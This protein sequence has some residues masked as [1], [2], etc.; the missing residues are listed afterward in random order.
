VPDPYAR[1]CSWYATTSALRVDEARRLGPGAWA[2]RTPAWSRSFVHNALLLTGDPGPE[3]VLAWSEQA[4]A[5][6]SHRHVSAYCQLSMA[7]LESL[8]A[9]CYQVQPEIVMGRTVAAGPIRAPHEVQVLAVPADDP[10]L[11]LLQARFWHEDWLPEAD[12]ATVGELV[13][14]RSEMGRAGTVTSVIVLDGG[15][16]VASLDVCVRGDIAEL[17][18]LATLASHRG[19]GYATA[20]FAAGI[21]LAEQAGAELVLLTALADD[22]PRHWY[23]RL[24]WQDLGPVTEATIHPGA[25]PPPASDD[26][27]R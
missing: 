4:C 14:R 10:R 2:L 3:V 23:T 7:T 13:G 11:D 27:P 21:D 19:R 15:E 6:L 8:A 25:A 1:S 17:D 26:A 18:A 9:N 20:L 22:W 24:G 5:G 16:A 12:E